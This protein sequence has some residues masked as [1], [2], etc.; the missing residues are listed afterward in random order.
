MQ[1]EKKKTTSAKSLETAREVLPQI[2]NETAF[3]E[4]RAELTS[5]LPEIA[6]G[7][8]QLAK[9]P[10]SPARSNGMST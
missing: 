4:A 9:T 3:G 2:E 10:G 1:A 8:A 5:L 6:E 7:F